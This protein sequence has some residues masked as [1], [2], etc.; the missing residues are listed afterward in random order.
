LLGNL[1]ESLG[2]K[3][4]DFKGI[5]V[6]VK[7]GS[8]KISSKSDSFAKHGHTA[9][10]KTWVEKSLAAAVRGL[11]DRV[12]AGEAAIIDKLPVVSLGPLVG[13]YFAAFGADKIE[14]SD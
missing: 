14:F 12:V 2:K 5:D 9:E 8:L 6:V 10:V 11:G 4:L 13:L 3:K 7:H 1:Q